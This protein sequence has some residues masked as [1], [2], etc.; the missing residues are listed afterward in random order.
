MDFSEARCGCALH[1]IA[2]ANGKRFEEIIQLLRIDLKPLLHR[3]K[4]TGLLPFQLMVMHRDLSQDQ[5]QQLIREAKQC[6]HSAF[7]W[8]ELSL[9]Q[10][11]RLLWKA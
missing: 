11:A 6:L 2:I 1:H 4:E 5:K 8:S 10:K 9:A 3:D 7:E